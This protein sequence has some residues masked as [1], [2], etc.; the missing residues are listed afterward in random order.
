MMI[1]SGRGG[2]GGG[3][4]RSHLTA[5]YLLCF[6]ISWMAP[7]PRWVHFAHGLLLFLYQTFDVVDWKTSKK[8]NC[9]KL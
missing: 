9:K 7:P 5:V 6:C 2:F 8:D 3:A 4:G 1:Y